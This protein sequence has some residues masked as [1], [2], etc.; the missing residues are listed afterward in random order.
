MRRHIDYAIADIHGRADL[1]TPLLSAC[2]EDSLRRGAVARFNFLGDIID[3]G[4]RSRDCLDMVRAIIEKHDGSVAIRGNHETYALE[5]MLS[6][7]PDDTSVERWMRVGGVQTLT[8]YSHDL[9][10]GFEMMKTVCRD[11][12]DLLAGMVCSQRR[13]RYLLA[14]AGI[15]PSKASGDQSLRDLTCI[16]TPFLDHVGYLDAVVI[17]GHSIVGDLPVVTE[18]R[19]SID[20]GAYRSGRLT[21]C[22]IDGTDLRFLQTDGCGRSVIEVEPVLLDRGLGTC[23]DIPYALA[24]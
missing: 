9:E 15:D 6:P 21:A 16:R 17:H 12:L 20:T 2:I 8:S 14:H 23:F 1:L 5:V 7:E 18:S 13:G 4:P 3:R 10:S 22:A 19:V 24:A 11:H